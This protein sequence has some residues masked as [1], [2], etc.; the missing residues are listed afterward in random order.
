M[1]ILDM[2]FISQSYTTNLLMSHGHIEYVFHQPIKHNHISQWAMAILDMC[3]IS[4][5][6]TTMPPHEQWPYWICV[7]STNQTQPYLTM[8]HGHIGYVLHQ[9]IKHNHASSWAIAIL[10][11][12]FISQSNT[13]ISYNEPWPYWI[14]VSSAN[15]TQPYL[16]MS[17]GHIGYVFHQPIIHNH[18]SWWAVAKWDMCYISQS[19]WISLPLYFGQS[20][21]PFS[22]VPILDA[23][24]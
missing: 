19:L 5:S 10:D 22:M 13:T 11:M 4:Q 21:T 12:C 23:T 20:E 1:A 2:C 16:T 9:P 7:S 6:N 8:S 18:F 24:S 14:C 15:Q 3:C 17:H